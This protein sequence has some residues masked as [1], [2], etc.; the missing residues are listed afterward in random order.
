MV[1]IIYI[2]DKYC[3]NIKNAACL[4]AVYDQ[5]S[6]NTVLSP[7]AVISESTKGQSLSNLPVM[8]GV[9]IL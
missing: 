1:I 5:G 8:G 3:A 7:E 9:L 6:T 4:L 2:V